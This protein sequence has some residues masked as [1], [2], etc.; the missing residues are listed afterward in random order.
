MQNTRKHTQCILCR[1]L[2]KGDNKYIAIRFRTTSVS[3]SASTEGDETEEGASDSA[4]SNSG[5]LV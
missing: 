1:T 2:A 3:E 5:K 4:K